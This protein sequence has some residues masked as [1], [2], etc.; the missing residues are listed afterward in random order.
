MF[1]KP[2]NA[3]KNVVPSGTL[4]R[5]GPSGPAGFNSLQ[6]ARPPG[7]VYSS[8]GPDLLFEGSIRGDG[9]L[10]IDGAVKGD[11]HVAHLVIGENAHVE[12]TVH[13]GAVEVRGRVIGNIEAQTVKLHETAFVEGDI[14][15]GQLSIDVGAYF[16]GRCQQRRPEPAVE[17]VAEV[18]GAVEAD[19]GDLS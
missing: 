6:P 13:C 11:V 2:T 7:S 5:S 12:G 14:T 10:L 17:P 15:H 16:Q 3:S 8:L 4:A 1:S 19:A 18:V 9:E